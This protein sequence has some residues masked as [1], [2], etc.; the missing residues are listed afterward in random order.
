MSVET[1]FGPVRVKS[2][3]GY[4]VRREKAEYD[5][6]AHEHGRGLDEICASVVK[7]EGRLE[8]LTFLNWAVYE[9]L[10]HY[11]ASGFT[12]HF[13]GNPEAVFLTW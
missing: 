10:R 7:R 9:D 2:S 3:E 12:G 8:P 4:G 6:L 13:N 1:E 5:D 11:T